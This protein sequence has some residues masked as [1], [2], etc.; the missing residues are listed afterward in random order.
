MTCS[1]A[2]PELFSPPRGEKKLPTMFMRKHGLSV[3]PGRLRAE[4]CRD[5]AVRAPG[6]VD[7]IIKGEKPAIF[8]DRA[9][10]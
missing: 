4:L 10:V 8:A 9:S 5:A 3:A 6:L 1:K 7:K 2:E